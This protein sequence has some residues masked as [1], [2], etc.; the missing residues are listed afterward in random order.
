MN[1]YINN[2]M[3]YSANYKISKKQLFIFSILWIFVTLIV[4]III[5]RQM[6]NQYIHE[7]YMVTFLNSEMTMKNKRV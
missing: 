4:G 6:K 5:V 2:M 1:D 7:A 3:D